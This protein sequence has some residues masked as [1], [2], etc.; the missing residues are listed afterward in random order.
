L[1]A[2]VVGGKD[3][4]PGKI[5]VLWPPAKSDLAAGKEAAGRA[6]GTRGSELS[7]KVFANT[8]LAAAATANATKGIDETFK[9]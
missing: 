4:E 5:N 7:G 3:C 9:R 8:E 1:R 2:T 6:D